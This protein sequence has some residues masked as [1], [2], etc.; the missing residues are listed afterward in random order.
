MCELR[1]GNQDAAKDHFSYVVKDKNATKRGDSLY[2]LG[3]LYESKGQ[4]DKAS[5]F[6]EIVMIQYPNT[7]IA[8]TAKKAKDSL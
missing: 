5:K 8:D 1:L 6:Y 4:K 3:K 2:Q 7:A